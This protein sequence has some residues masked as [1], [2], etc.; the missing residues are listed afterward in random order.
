MLRHP[1]GWQDLYRYR[2][3]KTLRTLHKVTGTWTRTSSRRSRHSLSTSPQLFRTTTRARATPRGLEPSGTP[4]IRDRLPATRSSTRIGSLTTHRDGCATFPLAA[5]RRFERRTGWRVA[6]LAGGRPWSL[7]ARVN[8][9]RMKLRPLPFIVIALVF[10][11]LRAYAVTPTPPT[12]EPGSTTGS[13]PSTY[14][15]VGD[16]LFGPSYA[17]D[18]KQVHDSGI[19]GPYMRC[20]LSPDGG[21]TCVTVD[22]GGVPGG[23]QALGVLLLIGLFW[24]LPG[25]L[26][27]RAARAR[28]LDAGAV[29][30]SWAIFGWLG[31]S[32][33]LFRAVPRQD[34]RDPSASEVVVNEDIA[35]RMHRAAQRI[36]DSKTAKRLAK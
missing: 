34:R 10:A 18:C 8:L 1:S 20:E 24:V 26:V 2:L 12:C 33:H 11:P 23:V 32:Y 27:Y 25:V 14:C 6:A 3:S 13:C 19:A 7:L 31:V 5:S 22:V 21:S 17:A 35:G 4:A 36:A 30:G 9:P 28:G 29:L 16:G 15:R